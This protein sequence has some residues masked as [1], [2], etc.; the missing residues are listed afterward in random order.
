MRHLVRRL[1]LVGLSAGVLLTDPPPAGAECI[2]VDFAVHVSG[3]PDYY[4]LGPDYCVTGTPWNQT[5][6]VFYNDN[7]SGLPTGTPS[8][9][10]LEI[11][12]TS[13]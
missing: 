4:P 7:H 8:G 9:F 6:S 13:P 5:D 2:E 11:W 1:L 3:E 12:Y 10:W